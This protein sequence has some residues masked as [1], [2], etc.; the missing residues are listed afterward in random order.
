MRCVY[1]PEA[2]HYYCWALR[3][4]QSDNFVFKDVYGARLISSHHHYAS[5]VFVA[6]IWVTSPASRKTCCIYSILPHTS[7]SNYMY[8]SHTKS[9][10]TRIYHK[11][12]RA[13]T[14][15]TINCVHT[16]LLWAILTTLLC[17]VVNVQS[18]FPCVCTFSCAMSFLG[19]RSS[20]SRVALNIVS[21]IRTALL[22][23]TSSS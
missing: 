7:Y 17:S 16:Q 21:P 10:T 14:N 23:W 13:A 15:Y 1:I 8:M 5:A 6:A 19:V 22:T 12:V 20:S 2:P 4:Q 11:C 18:C 3:L 9:V